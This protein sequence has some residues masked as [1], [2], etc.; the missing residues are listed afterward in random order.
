MSAFDAHFGE[1]L[2]PVLSALHG[3]TASI[4]PDGAGGSTVTRTVIVNR[5]PPAA[6]PNANRGGRRV[7]SVCIANDADDGLATV[8]E[9]KAQIELADVVG[10]DA[11]WLTLRRIINE[12][13]GVRTIAVA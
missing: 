1:G 4:R 11:R 13:G 7:Y 9:G 6:D 10:G 2:W 5:E 12:D 8:N 3:E